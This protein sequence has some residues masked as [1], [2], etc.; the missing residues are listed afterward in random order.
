MRIIITRDRVSMNITFVKIVQ[1]ANGLQ[2]SEKETQAMQYNRE[3][4]VIRVRK[5]L[6]IYGSYS[7]QEER[8]KH[9]DRSTN[10]SLG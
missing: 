4:T 9:V 8:E 3:E 1:E 2:I 7:G 10:T 6:Q 5:D